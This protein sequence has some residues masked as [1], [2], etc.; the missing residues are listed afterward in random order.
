MKCEL[1]EKSFEKLSD[2]N[3]CDPCQEEVGTPH[4]IFTDKNIQITGSNMPMNGAAL[5]LQLKRQK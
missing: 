2:D 5:A 1:C 3:L 4:E